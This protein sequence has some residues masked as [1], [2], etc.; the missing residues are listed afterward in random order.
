MSTFW[1]LLK[2]SIIVQAFVTFI[3]VCATTYLW[4]TGQ[5]VPQEL[6]AVLTLVI[7]FYFGSKTGFAQGA[8][9]E[10]KK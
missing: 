9:S 7:G 2:Q 6:L 10:L 3:L 4:V 8:Y 1:E 5:P